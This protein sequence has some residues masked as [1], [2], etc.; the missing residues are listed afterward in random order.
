VNVAPPHLLA[1]LREV[2]G[3]YGSFLLSAEGCVLSSDLPGWLAAADL[4]SAGPRLVRLRDTL[5]ESRDP[6][7]CVVRF[8]DHKLFLRTYAEGMLCMV[9]T[10]SVDAAALQMASA[11][12]VRR[13]PQALASERPPPPLP[14]SPE[15]AQPAP[16]GPTGSAFPGRGAP[17]ARGRTYRGRVVDDE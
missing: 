4:S 16:T 17:S 14:P 12:V 15:G 3:V 9:G 10:T 5:S 8:E 1:S 7:W 2:D 11:L 6:T 13:L